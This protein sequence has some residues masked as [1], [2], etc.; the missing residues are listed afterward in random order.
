MTKN[1]WKEATQ[2]KR[3][4]RLQIQWTW[5][6]GMTMVVARSIQSQKYR[7]SR[8]WGGTI[9]EID[10]LPPTKLHYL[11]VPQ[12]SPKV[13][14]TGDSVQTHDPMC[15]CGEGILYSIHSSIGLLLC[16]QY[17]NIVDKTKWQKDSS[18]MKFFQMLLFLLEGRASSYK[19]KTDKN[20][21]VFYFIFLIVHM[22]IVVNVHT[23]DCA[24]VMCRDQ[25]S[26]NLLE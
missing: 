1:T 9:E 15:V 18:N 26:L 16:P 10:P 4:L 5:W 3:L 12:P 24:Y 13:P 14:P 20:V 21:S 7:V 23:H 2:E 25:K 17:L 22:C 19:C 11:E 6:L 8:K